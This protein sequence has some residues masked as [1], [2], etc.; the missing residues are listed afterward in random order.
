MKPFIASFINEQTDL[1]PMRVSICAETQEAAISFAR[2][3][4]GDYQNDY[5]DH[6]IVTHVDTEEVGAYTFYV[7]TVEKQ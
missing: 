2:N 6:N 5:R 3:Y 1:Q 4:F 7:F